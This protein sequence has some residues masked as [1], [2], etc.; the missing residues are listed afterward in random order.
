MVQN[1]DEVQV[2]QRDGGES[3]RRVALAPPVNVEG[4]EV[5]END[6]A[7][8]TVEILE[9]TGS[10]MVAMD[11]SQ[12]DKDDDDVQIISPSSVK[13]NEDEAI[14]DTDQ[15]RKRL[16]TKNLSMF[17]SV[18]FFFHNILVDFPLEKLF[19]LL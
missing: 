2:Q 16:F 5:R 3:G 8:E 6:G 13:R 14:Q 9:V 11:D 15:G 19:L 10:S 17:T 12:D 4:Q 1:E 18:F 7:D